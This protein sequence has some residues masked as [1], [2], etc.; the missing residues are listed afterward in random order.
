MIHRRLSQG[1]SELSNGRQ[2]SHSITNASDVAAIRAGYERAFSLGVSDATN[3]LARFERR[4]SSYQEEA[5]KDADEKKR[6]AENAKIAESLLIDLA[7]S[8]K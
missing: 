2:P 6:K 3:A 7:P 4:I 8:N 5:K 1:I